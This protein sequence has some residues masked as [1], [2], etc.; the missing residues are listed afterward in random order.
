MI[1]KGEKE[2]SCRD[3]GFEFRIAEA[4]QISRIQLSRSPVSDLETRLA[5][6]GMF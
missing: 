6:W 4:Q 1:A 3:L 2:E 5:V